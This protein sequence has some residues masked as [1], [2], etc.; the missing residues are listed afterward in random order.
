M[1]KTKKVINNAFLYCDPPYLPEDKIV[2]QKQLLYTKEIFDHEEFVNNML[3]LTS[4]KYMIS[5][6]DS[7]IANEIYGKLEKYQAKELIRTINPQKSYKST[8]L[9]FSNYKINKE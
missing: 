8:E 7:K 3:K 5:M 2:N 6:T 1:L 9:I 4:A